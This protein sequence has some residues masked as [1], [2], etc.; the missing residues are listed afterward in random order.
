M[1]SQIARFIR[2]FLFAVAPGALAIETGQ[3]KLTTATIV[4]LVTPA[5]EVAWRAIHPTV[6][7][8]S[9]TPPNSGP[10]QPV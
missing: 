5:L 3:S 10:V 1:T 8:P 7:A 4:A 6:A 9:P 2:V